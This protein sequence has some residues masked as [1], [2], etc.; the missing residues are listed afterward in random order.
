MAANPIV[1]DILTKA[2]RKSAAGAKTT[3]T[4]K[5]TGSTEA[6]ESAAVD[7]DKKSVIELNDGK[8]VDRVRAMKDHKLRV[9]AE[10]KAAQEAQ[11]KKIESM[12]SGV[13]RRYKDYTK[14]VR[15]QQALSKEG[16]PQDALIHK[17]NAVYGAEL[18]PTGVLT[19][20]ASGK[21]I[22][23]T[24]AQII[25]E[26]IKKRLPE[27]DRRNFAEALEGLDE[28]EV[29]AY[30]LEDI[31]KVL[32]EDKFQPGFV[33]SRL[34]EIA[35]QRDSVE[36]D[37]VK[38]VADR[39]KWV[40]TPAMKMGYWGYDKASSA[41]RAVGN[42]LVSA[43]NRLYASASDGVFRSIGRAWTRAFAQDTSLSSLHWKNIGRAII[44][45][46]PKAVTYSALPGNFVAN[47]LFPATN[48]T[49]K[50]AK[51]K[52]GVAIAQALGSTATAAIYKSVFSTT[53]GGASTRDTRRND[54]TIRETQ[55]LV[56]VPVPRVGQ[57][58][59]VSQP[60]VAVQED[61][62]PEASRSPAPR[63]PTLEE[64]ASAAYA[65][66]FPS[67]SP[68]TRSIRIEADRDAYGSG[69]T[70]LFSKVYDEY[71]RNYGQ[72]DQQ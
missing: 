28:Y 30:G 66:E 11:N 48:F 38:F 13:A 8:P 46:A 19:R 40:D 68:L 53:D 5:R 14:Y 7:R 47:L 72:P 70:N 23:K 51:G 26:R 17:R 59:S 61:K 58:D 9:E 55:T 67:D 22:R 15:L 32:S 6:S 3:K 56:D 21:K 4:T 34:K 41:A 29:K 18:R 27:E 52:I 54:R 65:S 42:G 45:N 60:A 1:K 63:H 62:D 2:L 49:T 10:A 44:G 12:A 37:L 50:G 39:T 35:S 36:A 24:P 20:D 71:V 25:E 43:G 33:E 31:Q 16:V 57:G 64:F 69:G